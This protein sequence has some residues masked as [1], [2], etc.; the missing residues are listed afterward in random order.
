MAI[1][2]PTTNAAEY[3]SNEHRANYSASARTCPTRSTMRRALRRTSTATYNKEADNIGTRDARGEIRRASVLAQGQI[4]RCVESPCEPPPPD[5]HRVR[6][7]VRSIH[8]Q[9]QIRAP[10]DSPRKPADPRDGTPCGEKSR[11]EEEQRHAEDAHDERKRAAAHRSASSSMVAYSP[12]TMPGRKRSMHDRLCLS[13]AR[14]HGRHLAPC[15]RSGSITIKT[16]NRQAAAQRRA[17]PLHNR[18]LSHPHSGN[19]YHVANLRGALRA[20][21]QR[22][23][24]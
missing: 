8:D 2:R 6:E 11:D 16:S 19:F 18:H 12:G 17:K 23:R 4:R 7:L 24:K 20:Q 21:A 13:E 5:H 1:G 3:P 22:R 10:A 15:R 9:R 14:K